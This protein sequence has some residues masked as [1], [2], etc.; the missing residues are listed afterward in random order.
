V[1]LRL[2]ITDLTKEQ[3][4]SQLK[5]AISEIADALDVLFTSDAPNGNI[6]ARQGRIAQYKNG[7]AYETWQNVD[8]AKTWV[9]IDAGA[10]L[11]QGDWII[12]TVN[13]ARAGW[14][15]V[16]ATY[17]NKFMRISATPLTLG[18]ADTHSHTIAA[19]N[20][21]VHTHAQG[22]AADSAGAHTHSYTDSYPEGVDGSFATS[23]QQI[24]TSHSLTTG[25]N[26]AHTHTLSGSTGNNT[27]TASDITGANVP[28][29]VAVCTF[30]KN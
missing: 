4:L 30:Q 28:A 18:G 2:N 22:G 9:R 1:D 25:S 16:S 26:G 3:D 10:A 14:T 8:G 19:N 6:S 27:T 17:A 23:N 7:T 29:F 5:S 12:S 13:T 15:D 11:V 24:L 20:L 21:P